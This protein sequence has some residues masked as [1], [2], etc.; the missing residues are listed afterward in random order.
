MAPRGRWRMMWDLRLERWVEP[1]LA[2][3]HGN[4]MKA[5]D[6]LRVQTRERRY[7]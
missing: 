5:E 7:Q 1:F 2:E 4:E 6:L 3:A